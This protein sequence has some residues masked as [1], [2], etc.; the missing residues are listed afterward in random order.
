MLGDEIVRG[1]PRD[2]LE[3]VRSFWSGAPH[4][5]HEAILGVDD[6]GCVLASAAD[7]AERVARVLTDRGELAVANIHLDPTAG[8][9]D[10]ANAFLGD[11]MILRR[12]VPRLHVRWIAL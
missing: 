1:I 4:R 2:P 11:N 10:P 3:T 5:M 8:R 9:A 6:L 7:H 12:G